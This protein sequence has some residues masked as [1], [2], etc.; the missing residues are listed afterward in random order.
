MGAEPF[1]LTLI[2]CVKPISSFFAFYAS[3]LLFDNPG[4]IRVYLLINTLIGCL[5]CL[6]YPFTQNIW[7]YIGSYAL[8]MITL[9][10]V[11]P[12]WVEVLRT[13][14]ETAALSRVISQGTSI[15]YF[16]GIFLPPILCFYMDKQKNL[17]GYLFLGFACLQMLSMIFISFIDSNSNLAIRKCLINPFKKGWRLLKENPAFFHYQIVFFLGGAGIIGSQSIIPIYFKENLDLTYTQ[18]GLG[19]SFCKGISFILSSP[20]WAKWANR[21]SLYYL[22]CAVNLFTCLFFALIIAA[23]SEVS[24]LFLAYIFYGAMQAGC[25]MSWNLSGP[26]FS[27]TKESTIYSSLNLAVVGIRGCICPFLGYLLFVHTDSIT[28]FTASIMVCLIGTGYAFWLG[29]RD[30]RDARDHRDARDKGIMN[31]K[32]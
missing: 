9:R 6:F 3:S 8:F 31:A 17:W 12:A 26:F 25:E 29:N 24:W 21:I 28:V 22:N 23:N 4:R 2:A 7:F 13:G 5:P 32:L 10:A 16:L 1:Q 15:C 27:G 20:Y 18:L 11:Y 30:K 19:F 14:M